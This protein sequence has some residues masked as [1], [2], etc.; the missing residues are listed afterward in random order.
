MTGF[1][2][3]TLVIK[4]PYLYKQFIWTVN[5]QQMTSVFTSHHKGLTLLCFANTRNTWSCGSKCYIGGWRCTQTYC[6]AKTVAI[7][8]ELYADLQGLMRSDK[9]ITW[10]TKASHTSIAPQANSL[11]LVSECTENRVIQTYCSHN[12][13]KIVKWNVSLMFA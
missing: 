1:L 3:N 4:P 8:N 2:L 12:V 6:K 13:C 7:L 11:L 5:V 10:P 9:Y